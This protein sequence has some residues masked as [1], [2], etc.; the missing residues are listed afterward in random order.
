M[1]PRAITPK[2]VD[3]LTKFPILSLTGA[4]QSGKTTLLRE[5]FSDYRYVNLEQANV[6]NLARTDIR[7]FLSLYDNNVIFDEAQRVP[8]LFSELQVMVDERR[9]TPGQFILSG[10]QNFLLM[11]NI[12]QSLADAW[13]SCI[14]R[15][16]PIWNLPPP[17]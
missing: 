17:T 9:Q 6:A 14:C 11:N 7:S 13:P 10:S 16:C 15:H 3:L 1:I 12:T 2:M 5:Q 8:D 4:R